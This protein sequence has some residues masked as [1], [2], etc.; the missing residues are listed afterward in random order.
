LSWAIPGEA[1]LG[2]T[3]RADFFLRFARGVPARAEASL[4]S[5]E[6]FAV[7]PGRQWIALP[8]G[9]APLS[10]DLMPLRRGTGRLEQLWLRW[11]GPLGLAWIQSPYSLARELP[12][13]PDIATV[14]EEAMRL[15]QRDTDY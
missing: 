4:E 1:G 10:F 2:R 14:R 9:D 5:D 6:H 3:L 8:S 15:F 13:L 7:A 12:V 11:T